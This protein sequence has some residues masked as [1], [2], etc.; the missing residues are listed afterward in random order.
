MV[1]FN[2]CWGHCIA[3]RLIGFETNSGNW[4]HTLSP[5]DNEK[6]KARRV[7]CDNWIPLMFIIADLLFA[8][9]PP[10]INFENN[11]LAP[12]TT[13]CSTN[14]LNS[15]HAILSLYCITMRSYFLHHVFI[16][17][18]FMRC[19]D[20]FLYNRKNLNSD[21]LEPY[22]VYNKIIIQT[23]ICPKLWPLW[24]YISIKRNVLTS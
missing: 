22:N 24:L 21:S 6:M 19:C 1:D 14:R 3:I 12:R 5:R 2:I 23:W 16:L 13:D 20:I 17:T 4:K 11:F 8:I 10:F 7:T 18:M 9:H 15:Q